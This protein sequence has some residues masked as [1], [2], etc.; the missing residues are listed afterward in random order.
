[1]W[2]Y[3]GFVRRLIDEYQGT[4]HMGEMDETTAPGAMLA[5]AYGDHG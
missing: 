2:K 1:M 4:P 5:I 3:D